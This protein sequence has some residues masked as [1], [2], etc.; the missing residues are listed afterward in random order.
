MAAQWAMQRCKYFLLGLPSF[1]LC[2]D[3]KPLLVIFGHTE[4]VDIHNPQLF[5]ANLDANL[6]T[7]R[8]NST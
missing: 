7:F 6:S 4:L 3:H 1:Q 8:E 2:V 5:K